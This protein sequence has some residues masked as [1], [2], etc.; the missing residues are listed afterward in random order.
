MMENRLNLYAAAAGRQ[1]DRL[2]DK[3]TSY[4]LMLYYLVAL[5]LWAVIGSLVHQIPYHWYEIIGS[6]FILLAI[7]WAVNRSLASFLNIPANKESDLITALILALIMVPALSGGRLTALA[8]AAAVAITSKFVVTVY[9]SHVFNPAAAGA[10]MAGLTTHQYAAW[11]VGTKFMIPLVFIGGVLVMRK[12]K[13]F[14]MVAVFFA[15]YFLWLIYGTNAGGNVHFLWSALISTQLLFFGYVMLLEP[16]TSPTTLQKS[17]LY[18]IVVGVFYSITKLGV[19]PEAALLLGNLLVFLIEPKKR[20]AVKFI[21]KVREAEGI[22]SYIFKPPRN[23]SY[24]AGQYMEWTMPHNRTDSRGN[25]RYLTISSSPTEKELMFTVKQPPENPS[26]FKQGLEEIRPDDTLLASY[27]SGSFSLPED[28][29]K[30]LAFLAGGVGITPYRSMVKYLLDSDEKRDITLLYSAAS[31]S[32][33][34]FDGLFKKAEAIGLKS[35]FLTDR[36]IDRPTI[37]TFIPDYAERLFYISGPY[38]FVTTLE[39]SLIKMGLSTSQIN[40]DYFPGY[41][42]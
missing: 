5:V 14:T 37:A 10:Y 29:S 9:K 40:T 7:C 30:K 41:G 27:L 3:L 32:E 11:W 18:S 34:A 12:M 26:V 33:L 25:R 31:P 35:G 17:L 22:Y 13:R 1:I 16:Q 21:K 38:G 42:G 2:N 15:F 24:S 39:S 6:A 28:K 23:F 20:Y 4:R 8:I 19:S 36:R